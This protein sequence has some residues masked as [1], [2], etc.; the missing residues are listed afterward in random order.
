MSGE[1]KADDGTENSKD[2]KKEKK[3][4]SD[5]RGDGGPPGLPD[6]FGDPVSLL[7]LIAAGLMLL[8]NASSTQ[9]SKEISWQQFKNDF[10][11]K[12]KV[13][14]IVVVNKSVCKVF[15]RPEVNVQG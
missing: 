3:G 12:G 10:L 15:L 13:E 14:K 7:L 5:G 1:T 11:L 4:E 8:N 9:G 2:K 6:G